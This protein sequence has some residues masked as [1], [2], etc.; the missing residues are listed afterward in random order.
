MP[1]KLKQQV[2]AEQH[3]LDPPTIYVGT[4]TEDGRRK[5]KRTKWGGKNV[6]KHAQRQQEKEKKAQEQPELEEQYRAP[7][8]TP[9]NLEEALALYKSTLGPAANYPPQDPAKVRDRKLKKDAER[10]MK[11]YKEAT[12]P[13]WLIQLGVRTHSQAD[14]DAWLMAAQQGKDASG[15]PLTGP[16]AIARECLIAT[17]N[18]SRR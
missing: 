5:L 13:N 17:L 18:G 12:D 14:H 1:P 9:L 7:G 10:R 6:N 11:S 2:E 4:E 8:P 16:P 3:A 15:P